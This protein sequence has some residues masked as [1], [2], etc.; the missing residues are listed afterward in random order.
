MKCWMFTSM[1]STVSLPYSVM[2]FLGVPVGLGIMMMLVPASIHPYCNAISDNFLLNRLTDFHSPSK[3]SGN[4]SIALSKSLMPVVEVHL[5]G[6]SVF[7]S[8]GVRSNWVTVGV[9][10]T[11]LTTLVPTGTIPLPSSLLVLPVE[12]YEE[13]DLFDLSI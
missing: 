5:M 11:G 2:M 1:F 6:N 10:G 12:V 4:L 3:S 7:A 8:L 13:I 9:L